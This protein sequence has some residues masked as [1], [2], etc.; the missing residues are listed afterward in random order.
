ME[1]R[2]V[3]KNAVKPPLGQLHRQKILME[4]LALRMRT[5]HRDELLRSVEPH[6]LMPQGS[7]VT[8][9]AAGPT[10]KIEDRIGRVT[11][12]RIE[13]RRVILADIVVSRAVPESP[14]EPIVKRDR[15]G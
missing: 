12:Y 5:R 13:E 15:R 6:R 8:E 1:E 4:N 3:C 14:G 9:I 10:T 7:K 11:L 2:G